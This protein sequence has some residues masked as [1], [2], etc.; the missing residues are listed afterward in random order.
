MAYGLHKSCAYYMDQQS[1]AKNGSKILSLKK[2]DNDVEKL[3]MAGMNTTCA[4]LQAL[5]REQ[6]SS[7][8]L[9]KFFHESCLDSPPSREKKDSTETTKTKKNPAIVAIIGSNH[10][11]GVCTLLENERVWS[12]EMMLQVVETER[13]TRDHPYTLGIVNH[14]EEY[15]RGVRVNSNHRQSLFR[16]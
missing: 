3:S 7:I 8:T 1:Q 10:L 15:D 13:Y 2:P 16:Q 5:K 11:E 12:P 9:N 6:K 14:V 4:Q